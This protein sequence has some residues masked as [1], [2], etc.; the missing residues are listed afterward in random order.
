VV[1][2]DA[3][4]AKALEAIML[5]EL[6]EALVLQVLC[7]TSSALERS[8]HPLIGKPPASRPEMEI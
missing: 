1:I 6:L 4:I 2:S 8:S 5:E 3:S 7:C